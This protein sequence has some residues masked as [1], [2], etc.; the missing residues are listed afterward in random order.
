MLTRRRASSAALVIL[1]SCAR[2]ASVREVPASPPAAS[3]TPSGNASRT[4]IVTDTSKRSADSLPAADSLVGDG[5]D[6]YLPPM[7]DSLS[8]S[9]KPKS[10]GPHD[11]LTL[12][13]EAPHGGE[14]A[15]TTPDKTWYQ[16]VYRPGTPNENY[17]VVPSETFKTMSMLKVP[18]AIRLPP[19]VYG[20]DTPEVVFSRG[21]QYVLVMGENL[22][23]D[24]TERPYIC[25]V[26]FLPR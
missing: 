22:H 19:A 5:D 1:A 2:E 13:M 10:F 12:R 24:Y 26:T 11:T 17:S 14:V 4:P 18:A 9:C 3:T 6:D 23:S 20:R 25:S 8:F 21:G 16:F 7:D 15:V